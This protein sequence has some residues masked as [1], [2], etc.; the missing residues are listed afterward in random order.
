[1]QT[2]PERW[3]LIQQD[4]NHFYEF[5]AV[6]AGKEYLS[7]DIWSA[8]INFPMMEGLAIGTVASASLDMTFTPD[9]E[10]Q[11]GAEIKC[12]LRV[13]NNEPPLYILADDG[14]SIKTD[15][16][17]ILAASYPEMSGWLP[18]G[19]FYINTRSKAPNGRLTVKA[20]DAMVKADVD[21][22][23]NSGSYPMQMSAAMSLICNML[24]IELDSR[25]QIAPY[26][27]DSPTGVYTIHEVI[28]GVA[29][30]S[31]ANAFITK[32]GKMLIKRV[33]SPSASNESPTVNCSVYADNA[34][35]IGRV[36]L[37][38]DSDTQYS[39]GTSG[40]EIQADC[41]Y[42][43][44]AICDY[45]R[46]ILNGVTYLPYSATTAFFDPVLEL[47]DS[48]N[49]NGNLSIL[50]S[51]SYT[52]GASMAAN[53]EATIDA[54]TEQEYPYKA[55]TREERKNAAA[56][57]EIRKTTEEIRLSVEGKVD[58]DDV[59]TAIDLNLNELS[60]SYT[61]GENGASIT[62]SKEGVSIT[63][64]VKV[65]SIDASKISVKN[66]DA[67][68]ITTGTLSA[69]DIVGCTIYA[70]QS[71]E[72][73][74][75]M[76]STGL[77]VYTDGSYKMG[78]YVDGT[79]PTLELGNTTPAYVQ[80]LYENSAHKMWIGNAT[81]RDGIMIDFTNHTI[82]KIKNGVETTL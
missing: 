63:G 13:A 39:S 76:T 27:I 19:T 16:G 43:T 61:A 79:Y 54:E 71:K 35:T 75:K 47:G 2:K 46:G 78:F 32:D 21:Y 68:E 30:A 36:T 26:T 67:A 15:D 77:E 24:G 53:I 31:G 65:G 50:A 37:Y 52:V 58:A 17:Y 3:D 10:I 73:Y 34:V 80:K 55:R 51:V 11:R 18:F 28:A 56:F 74:A 66:L 4:I 44:Q 49:V 60:L 62:L 45:V 42:A 33:A 9:G 64:D 72:D 22:V 57:S 6:I 20:M 59:Q 29:A 81:G 38:P 40:Y 25:S 8:S 12:Y 1:M 23:D 41:I 5:K 7:S 82:T 69:I 14:S 70:T 48:I